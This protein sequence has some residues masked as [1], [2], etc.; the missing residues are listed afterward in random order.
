MK[1]ISANEFGGWDQYSVDVVMS[2]PANR[3]YT[4]SPPK[5]PKHQRERNKSFVAKIQKTDYYIAR[6]YIRLLRLQWRRD[7]H[8]RIGLA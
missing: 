6:D 5:S 7:Y 8:F 1:A 2:T 3:H 4:N